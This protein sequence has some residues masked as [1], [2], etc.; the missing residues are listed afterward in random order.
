MTFSPRFL[1]RP[2][3]LFFKGVVFYHKDDYD[4]LFMPL[5]GGRDGIMVT[6]GTSIKATCVCSL[7]PPFC[8][9][10]QVTSLSCTLFSL[11]A[12][13]RRISITFIFVA[14]LKYYLQNI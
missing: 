6:I 13:V 2:I 9:S 4:V 1:K 3:I 5:L 11:G 14:P 7:T 8:D 12:G 10:E